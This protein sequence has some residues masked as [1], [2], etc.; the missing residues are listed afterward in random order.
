MSFDFHAENAQQIVDIYH[1][2]QSVPG[3]MAL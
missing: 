2:V 1:R 3:L